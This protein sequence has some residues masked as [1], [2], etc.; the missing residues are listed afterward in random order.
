MITL[1]AAAG[2]IPLA[3]R[4]VSARVRPLTLVPMLI[5]IVLFKLAISDGGRFEPT[6][7]Q[8]QVVVYLAAAGLLVTQVLRRTAVAAAITALTAVA[9]VT[10]AWSVRPDAS[11]RQVLLWLLYLGIAVSVESALRSQRV[12][13]WFA[14]AL[15]VIAGWLCLIALLV[16]WGAG[17]PGMRWYSTFYWPN[18]FAAFLVLALPIEVFRCIHAARR[19][20]LAHGCLCT[21]LAAALIL[22]YSRGAWLSLL[23]VVP[24]AAILLRPP[25][26]SYA[27]ARGL[28]LAA[29]V[30]VTVVALTHGPA[31]HPG[32][33]V[34]SRVASVIDADDQSIQGRLHFWR[35]AWAIFLDHPFGTG[36]GT[37]GAVHA[38]YQQDP[39]FYSA[40][41]HNL[42]LQTAAEMG[43]FGLAALAT[44]LGSL[45]L[46]G[47]RTIG[48]ARGTPLYPLVAGA[49]IAL[50]A[51]FVHSGVEMNWM[52]PADPAAAFALVGM[53]AGADHLMG[54]GSGS[55][56]IRPGW[57]LGGATVLG[58]AAI[59]SF[60]GWT[61]Q[62]EFVY[63]QALARAGD[64]PAAAEAYRRAA[65]WNPLQPHYHAAR[66]AAL[67]QIDPPRRDAAEAALRRAMAVDRMNASHP[68]QLAVLLT[69]ARAEGAS[70]DAEAE[71]LLHRAI[72]LDPLNRPEV[73][74]TLARLY[75]QE[76]R[77]DAAQEV[78][79]KAVARYLGH[80]LPV[81]SVIYALLW[82]EVVGL[83]VDAAD[84]DVRQGELAQ[85][86]AMLRRLLAE[87]PGAVPAAVR[88]SEVYVA[89]GRN[90]DARTVLLAAAAQVPDSP[91]LLQ[92]L[93]RIP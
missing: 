56:V 22:T 53:L 83:V 80:G 14:D 81:G 55:P 90:E 91:E 2:R 58:L 28:I 38:A 26:W 17:N 43:V 75:L 79:G 10:A 42:Y 29:A 16:F 69:T 32:H 71:A 23:A 73:Y 36:A 30:A 62:R 82:P 44:L 24:V 64:W 66:A 6:L 89:M 74:R 19:E 57:R 20:A 70:R 93:L 7:A 67:V 72:R 87:Y 37:F 51:F 27:M 59:A 3:R 86:A 9:A 50:L 11:V 31:L 40:D 18:P 78:Y 49:G 85:A 1:V 12:F 88:L 65:R 21:L 5:V 48:A 61:A 84:L 34:T 45:L 35:A 52:F 4:L 77:P 68:Y 8:A 13:Q 46:L 60:V 39:R 63:G 76:A 54:G 92:A 41:A 25:S 15:V 47:H 33:E